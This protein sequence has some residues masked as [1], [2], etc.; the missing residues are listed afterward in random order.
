MTELNSN[1]NLPKLSKTSLESKLSI[2]ESVSDHVSSIE[3]KSKIQNNIPYFQLFTILHGGWNINLITYRNKKM[4]ITPWKASLFIFSSFYVVFI[5]FILSRKSRVDSTSIH[6]EKVSLEQQ[7]SLKITELEELSEN[8]LLESHSPFFRLA[9]NM[10]SYEQSKEGTYGWYLDKLTNTQSIGGYKFDPSVKTQLIQ[11]GFGEEQTTRPNWFGFFRKYNQAHCKQTACQVFPYEDSRSYF[12]SGKAE[13]ISL[14]ANIEHLEYRDRGLGL[15]KVEEER[16]V[17]EEIDNFVK[18]NS[19]LSS[20]ELSQQF[21]KEFALKTWL[22]MRPINVFLC[23]E[24]NALREIEPHARN[25]QSHMDMTMC[26]SAQCSIWTTYFYTK[27]DFEFRDSSRIPPH[28]ICAFISNCVKERMDVVKEISNVLPVRQYGGC[29]RNAHEQGGKVAEL[30]R[31]CKF[32]LAFENSMLDDYITEKFFEGFTPLGLGGKLVSIYR[33][34]PNINEYGFPKDSFISIHD[35]KSPTEMAQHIKP[36]CDDD[37]KFNEYFKQRMSDETKKGIQD[38]SLK[39]HLANVIKSPSSYI[40][41]TQALD[42]LSTDLIHKVGENV[43]AFL[44]GEIS[45]SAHLA[46]VLAE[47]FNRGLIGRK[48]DLSYLFS[49]N[50]IFYPSAVGLFF[51]D[52]V[53]T[54]FNLTIFPDGKPK[55]SF[56][57]YVKPKGYIGVEQWYANETDGS[58]INLVVNQTTPFVITSL[59]Y[60]VTSFNFFDLYQTDRVYGLPYT[61]VNSTTCIYYSVKLYDP[62]LLALNG[63]K[64][65]IGISKVNLSLLNIE[66]FLKTLTLIGDGYV[67]VSETNDFVIGGS[68]NTTAADS[69]S[70]VKIFDLIA[71]DSGALMSGIAAKYSNLTSSPSD[72][73]FTSKGVDYLI[74]R[75]SFSLENIR[76]NVFLVVYKSDIAKTTNINTG[77][78]VGVAVAVVIVGLILSIGIGYLITQPLRYLESQFFLIKKFDLENVNFISSKFREV[79]RI[80]EDLHEMVNWLNEFKSFLPETIFNQLRNMEKAEQEQSQTDKNNESMKESRH[81]LSNRSSAHSS[82]KSSKHDLKSGGGLFKLG[83]SIK[84]VSIVYIHL[85]EFGKLN[86]LEVTNLFA[87]VASGLS[88]LAK[89]L[90][91]DLQI[92][93]VEEFQLSFA[94]CK[95]KQNLAA[96]ESA[97]KVSKV[98]D[99]LGKLSSYSIGIS[100]GMANVGNLGTN[101]LRYYS[102]V[103]PMVTNSKNLS[104]LGC[105]LGCKI[106]ADSESVCTEATSAFVVRPVERFVLENSEGK[107]PTVVYEV[108]KEN[109][110]EKDEWMYELEQQKANKK[111]KDFEAAFAIFDPKTVSSMSDSQVLDRIQ[112]SVNILQD[113]LNKYPEDQIITNRLLT[114]LDTLT[115]QKSQNL[116][117]ALHNYH[118]TLQKSL[119][120][121]SHLNDKIEIS[122]INIA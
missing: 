61:V 93:S 33:G 44:K 29:G 13:G 59:A 30:A 100:S 36:Y 65:T 68:I 84:P 92:L 81:S 52:E 42:S 23:N 26:W 1:K 45:P 96:M 120:G 112:E 21:D 87:K 102:I 6:P 99:N 18:S 78:S 60:W 79:N 106:L 49:K 122:S 54:Y 121:I 97:L 10:L 24:P 91:A 9:Q 51:P 11:Y 116:A 47:D 35:F 109:S 71:K 50:Q 76:W 103:G 117:Q 37:Q 115:N 113:H 69:K 86:P 28:C 95:K 74:S 22:A 5:V 39:F 70:R 4:K 41:S 43:M 108:I 20:V 17:Q 72:F 19:D 83:L 40:G 94:D 107:T 25:D 111:F 15:E 104:I 90:Q 14:D 85:N 31:S 89:S 3:Q 53:N 66:K 114:I 80:Y 73:E 56:T 63:T 8:P 32:Y 110:Y 12:T 105:S 7:P 58:F 27:M 101:N 67:L 82:L 55:Q 62:Y 64:K 118:T 38:M 119:K 88:V 16:K 46:R 77:I 2:D 98:L 57:Y 48:P 75:L 34:A